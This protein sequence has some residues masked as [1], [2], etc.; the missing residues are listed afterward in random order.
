MSG[1]LIL[2]CL[3]VVAGTVT[4]FRP[5]KYQPYPGVPLLIAAPVL[6][7]LLG[8]E[9]G[10]WMVLVALFAFLSKFRRPLFYYLGKLRGA[11]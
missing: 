1:L 6:I 8:R 7:V 2:A 10:V 3:W 5:M 4:A 9:Y 11:R